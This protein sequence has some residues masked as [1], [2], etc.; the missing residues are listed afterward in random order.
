MKM[1]LY[2]LSSI[3]LSVYVHVYTFH[4]NLAII[5]KMKK[6]CYILHASTDKN[7]SFWC[8]KCFSD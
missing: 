6:E 2:V 1:N 3:I 4:T 8:L 5:T 7:N